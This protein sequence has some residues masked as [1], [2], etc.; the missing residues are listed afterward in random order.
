MLYYPLMNTTERGVV[1]EERDP[2]VVPFHRGRFSLSG[3][4]ERDMHPLLECEGHERR[5]L[6][7]ASRVT[8]QI[9]VVGGQAPDVH[10]TL[11]QKL[12]TENSRIGI[13]L[14]KLRQI[15]S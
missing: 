11:V 1:S 12:G 15:G 9:E 4:T 10:R 8:H 3:Y 6:L 7:S 2:T 14:E 13:I 5:G